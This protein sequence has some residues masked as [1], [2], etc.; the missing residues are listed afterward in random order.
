[1]DSA[2]T[3]GTWDISNA[4]RIGKGEVQLCNI[5]I[6]GAA[7]LVQWENMM[8]T[9][10]GAEAEAQISELVP[11]YPPL[12]LSGE[13]RARRGAVPQCGVLLVRGAWCIGEGTQEGGSSALAALA[14]CGGVDLL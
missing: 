12:G 8:E 6:E 10:K 2:S 14:G 13:E 3:G 1:M 9:G 5:L 11:M 4:D 7:K